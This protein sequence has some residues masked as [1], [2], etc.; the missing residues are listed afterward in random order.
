M[1]LGTEVGL[2]LVDFVLHGVAAPPKRGTTTNFRFMSTVAKTAGWMKIE[3]ATW[4]GSRPLTTPHC[5]RLCPSSPRKGY[6]SPLLFGPC[7]LWS[8]SP[9]SATA[10]LLLFTLTVRCGVQRVPVAA[11]LRQLGQCRMLR[12][13]RCQAT[14]DVNVMTSLMTSAMTSNRL[15][16]VRRHDTLQLLRL[17]PSP[18]CH[19]GKRRSSV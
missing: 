18:S 15:L 19:R 12:R 13:V 11:C 9:I 5:I 16:T 3:D 17:R 1:P 2:S 14:V 4:Y 6:S 8:W 10:E 7:L